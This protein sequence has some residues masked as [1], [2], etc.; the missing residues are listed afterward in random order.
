M[1]NT[2]G[3]NIS[4][5]LFGESHGDEIGIIIDG[6]APGIKIDEEE[7]RL[8]LLRRRP[9]GSISTSRSE[10]DEYRIVSG[11]FNGFTTGTPLCILI[12]NTNKKSCDY[13]KTAYLPRPG[14]ADYTAYCKY[15]GFQD[16]RGGGHFSGRLT[17]PIVAAG[18]IAKS[19]L[20]SKG[21]YVGTH[22]KKMAGIYDRDFDAKSLKNDIDSLSKS[23]FPVLSDISGKE[24]EKAAKDA[25]KE[26]DSVGGILETAVVGMPEGIGEP[27]FDS[28]ES[29]LHIP[30]IR[31]LIRELLRS[32]RKFYVNWIL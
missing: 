27:W 13:S 6:L 5:T 8:Q 17:A 29:V 23:L 26:G 9:R 10:M 20:A 19:I 25:A 11:F 22:I 28:V 4:F 3:Q 1:K 30:L 16:I 31:M 15:H 24:M 18:A 32:L 2:F 14:H 21:I 12:P 7:I